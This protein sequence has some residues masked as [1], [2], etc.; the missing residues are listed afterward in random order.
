MNQSRRFNRVN[1]ARRSFIGVRT[2]PGGLGRLERANISHVCNTGLQ[3][4]N[5][6]RLCA[7]V[8]RA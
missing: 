3:I 7:G 8:V 2:Q 6:A 4:C 5:P 1:L